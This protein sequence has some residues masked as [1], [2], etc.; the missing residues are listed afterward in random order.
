MFK[1]A[2]RDS[3][4][5]LGRFRLRVL[6]NVLCKSPCARAL[7]RFK[8]QVGFGAVRRWVRP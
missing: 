8:R 3:K 6:D 4:R 2:S 1:R 5:S 7:P